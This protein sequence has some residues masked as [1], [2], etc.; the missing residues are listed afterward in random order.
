MSHSKNLSIW[1]NIKVGKVIWLLTLSDIF[2]WGGTTLLNSLTGLYI[3]LRLGE[4]AFM[5]M[6][7][8]IT[9]FFLTRAIFQLPIGILL[10]KIKKDRDEIWAL[11]IGVLLMG[12]P[13]T[14]YPFAQHAWEFYLLHFVYGLG[15]SL[16]LNAWRKLFAK[17]LDRGREG[18][19]YGV[20]ETVMS[21][22]AALFSFLGGSFA[23]WL[24]VEQFGLVIVGIGVLIMAA[25]I[26]AILLFSVENRKSDK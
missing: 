22:G 7:T 23:N 16:N 3:A 8:T 25:G 11:L 26:W 15:T 1:E 20:Y 19:T 21:L 13:F 9:I 18:V 6:G 2:T 17:N 24:D 4:N 5:V 12:L 14:L 10:D